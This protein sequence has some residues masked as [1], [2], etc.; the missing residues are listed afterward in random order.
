MIRGSKH[1]KLCLTVD[2]RTGADFC[3]LWPIEKLHSR[4]KE[5]FYLEFYYLL[6]ILYELSSWTLS[7]IKLCELLQLRPDLFTHFNIEWKKKYSNIDSLYGLP[8]P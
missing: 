1:Q 5:A 2:K 4:K 8:K 7:P 6:V 3:S